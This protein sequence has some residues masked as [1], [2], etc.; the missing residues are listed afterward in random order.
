MTATKGHITLA[1]A[2]AL[3]DRQADEHQVAVNASGTVR[4]G[5]LTANPSIVTSDASTAPMRVA[6]AKAGFVTQRSAGDG[7]AI[8]GN[9]GSLFVT[10]TKPGSNSHIVTVYAK[11]NDAASGD[12]NNSP[13]IDVVTGTAAA[14]PVEAALP[15]GALKLATILIPSTATSTQSGGVVITNV[16]PMTAMRGGVVPVRDATELTAWTPGDSGLAYQ[17]DTDVVY[18]RINGAWAGVSDVDTGW[19]LCTSQNTGV[20]TVSAIGGDRALSVRRI[21][22]VVHLA[23][24]ISVNTGTSTYSIWAFVPAGFRPAKNEWVTIIPDGTGTTPVRGFL[25]SAGEVTFVNGV[26]SGS[27][28][29]AATYF[30]E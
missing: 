5:V 21:N 24:H 26:S 23:G 2:T 19:T 22:K 28:F 20:Y 6:V 8:W 29:L 14:S 4:T 17:I 15:A 7:V 13:I 16:Y 18:G 11:H 25:T 9:D 12:A 30:I 1:A 3:D 27:Y 10:V